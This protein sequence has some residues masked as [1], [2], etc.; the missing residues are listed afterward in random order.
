MRFLPMPRRPRRALA[1]AGLTVLPILMQ[2]VAGPSDA[3]GWQLAPWLL[4]AVL[5]VAIGVHHRRGRAARELAAAADAAE[6]AAARAAVAAI[7][8][9]EA[10]R[11]GVRSDA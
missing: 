7:A 8:A 4:L 3:P 5:W 2:R 11:V 10:R 1:L 6:L 9:R